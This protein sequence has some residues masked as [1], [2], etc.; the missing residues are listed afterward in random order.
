MRS[1]GGGNILFSIIGGLP[2]CH[3]SGG[4][5]AHVKGGSNHWISN[6]IIGFVLLILSLA[7]YISG[8]FFLVYPA[9]LIAILLFAVGYFHLKLAKPSWKIYEY[10]LQLIAMAIVAFTTKNM[11]W[12]LLMGIIFEAGYLILK[13]IGKHEFS[14]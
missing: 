2:F 13:R 1:I 7:V 4:I 8:V 9:I 12:V 5:T 11:L 6:L 3:G 14:S 10:R